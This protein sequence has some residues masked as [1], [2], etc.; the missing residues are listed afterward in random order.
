MKKIKNIIVGESGSGKTTLLNILGL[1]LSN[2]TGEVL[3]N[4]KDIKKIDLKSLREK[5]IYI[6]QQPV[7]FNGSIKDNITLNEE[8]D[9]FKKLLRF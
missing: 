1:R 5:I 3:I 8:F 7:F 9:E 2:Y 6:E 4:G